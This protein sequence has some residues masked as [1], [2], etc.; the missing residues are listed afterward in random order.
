VQEDIEKARAA[1]LAKVKDLGRFAVTGKLE[2]SNIYGA[3]AA[4]KYY[5]VIGS[6]G[7]TVCYAASSLVDASKLVGKKIGLVGTIEPHPQ[8]GT[9]LVTFTEIAEIE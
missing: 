9:A 2:T 3:D 5:R 6:S 7:K 1:R 4:L 8:T